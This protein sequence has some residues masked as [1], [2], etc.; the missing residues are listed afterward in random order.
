MSDIQRKIVRVSELKT[1]RVSLLVRFLPL[2][3]SGRLA[4]RCRDFP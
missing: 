1:A 2:A 4:K 3:L